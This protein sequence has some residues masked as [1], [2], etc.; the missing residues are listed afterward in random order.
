M[1][2][3]DLI[4]VKTKIQNNKI[5]MQNYYRKMQNTKTRIHNTT[6]K[7]LRI[8]TKTY[9]STNNY[10]Q[11]FFFPPLEDWVCPIH[12][13]GSLSCYTTSMRER[14]CAPH[15]GEKLFAAGNL[16]YSLLHIFIPLRL[17]F[18]RATSH[19]TCF[20]RGGGKKHVWEKSR[21]AG[22]NYKKRDKGSDFKASLH[23]S[24]SVVFEPLAEVKINKVSE[25]EER[26]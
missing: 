26:Q 22:T 2:D 10:M 8:T 7:R 25:A 14:L 3:R 17:C 21:A 16:T 18:L 19:I 9:T 12:L 5:E 4:V 11:R 20:L 23:P 24:G 1:Y 15:S 13:P 6:P